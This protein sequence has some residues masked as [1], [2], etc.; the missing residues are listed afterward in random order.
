MTEVEQ[1][2]RKHFAR[3]P[4]GLSKI[5]RKPFS[6]FSNYWIDLGVGGGG[7]GVNLQLPKTYRAK[8]FFKQYFS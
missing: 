6:S 3:D 8:H 2:D 5:H 1:V 4:L 7:G